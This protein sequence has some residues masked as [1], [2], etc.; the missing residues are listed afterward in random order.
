[1]IVTTANVIVVRPVPVWC[2]LLIDENVP[3]H[4]GQ[5]WPC[6]PFRD[7]IRFTEKVRFD[8]G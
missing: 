1:M 8:R 6:E 3:F 4:L 5:A 7:E 2:Y